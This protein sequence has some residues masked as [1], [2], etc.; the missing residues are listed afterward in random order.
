MRVEIET[1]D[2]PEGF[3]I[4]GFRQSEP[5][6]RW[7]DGIEWSECFHQSTGTYLVAVKA[8]PLWE[9][10]PELLAVLMPGWIAK[11]PAGTWF[12]YREKPSKLSYFWGGTTSFGLRI[13]NS[14]LLPPDS[15]PWDK[16]CF[17]IGEPQE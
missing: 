9:P 12:W 5:D 6:E 11:A 8:K 14:K 2:P 1:P 7:W 13:I 4:D 3:V 17:K 16:S 10:S 15:T